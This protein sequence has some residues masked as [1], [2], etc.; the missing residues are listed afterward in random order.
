MSQE[1]FQGRPERAKDVSLEVRTSEG[2]GL[3]C[4]HCHE[5]FSEKPTSLMYELLEV[6]GK[7]ASPMSGVY[8]HD[9]CVDEL[10]KEKPT[11][12]ETYVVKKLQISY[13]DFSRLNDSAR[14]LAANPAEQ[15]ARLDDL[16]SDHK[17]PSNDVPL[18]ARIAQEA[19]LHTVCLPYK[20][21][22]YCASTVLGRNLSVHDRFAIGVGG[23]IAGTT[24][25]MVAAM[26]GIVLSIATGSEYFMYGILVAFGVGAGGVL[27]SPITSIAYTTIGD[28]KENRSKSQRLP[29]WVVEEIKI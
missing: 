17:V 28:E 19:I 24:G 2:H 13:L 11:R 8:M 25:S 21:A 16:L 20:L 1:Q 27:A 5:S 23:L 6:R 14:S 3:S 7:I 10:K 4:Y 15:R 12:N 9:S 29:H 22:D 26:A 18:S